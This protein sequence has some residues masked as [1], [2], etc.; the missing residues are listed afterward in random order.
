MKKEDF[1]AIIQNTKNTLPLQKIPTPSVSEIF[2]SETSFYRFFYTIH[3]F[4]YI[5]PKNFL[6]NDWLS[7]LQSKLRIYNTQ[8]QTFSEEHIQ[9][10]IFEVQKEWTQI[11]QFSIN[12]ES[13]KPKP[14]FISEN[15]WKKQRMKKIFE[16]NTDSTE[17]FII[18]DDTKTKIITKGKDILKQIISYAF[19]TNRFQ[20]PIKEQFLFFVR[21]IIEMELFCKEQIPGFW[22]YYKKYRNHQEVTNVFHS[23]FK[24]KIQNENYTKKDIELYRKVNSSILVPLTSVMEYTC[25]NKKPKENPLLFCFSHYEE[26]I[27]FLPEDLHQDFVDA[28]LFPLNLLQSG[29][30]IGLEAEQRL[31]GEYEFLAALLKK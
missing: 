10:V 28:L 2:S 6:E 20:T 15:H 19:H 24:E 22:D 5:F 16:N 13:L 18:T 3:P 4:N 12:N 17:P 27:A 31:L 9:G 14:R 26:I 8:S 11:F 25:S 1:L 7:D 29:G 21:R 30:V 23:Y